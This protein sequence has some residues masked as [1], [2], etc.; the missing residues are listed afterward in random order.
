MEVNVTRG[1]Q[2]DLPVGHLQL[3]TEAITKYNTTIS[4]HAK[5]AMV[6]I[7]LHITIAMIYVHRNGRWCL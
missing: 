1:S 4:Q 6:R 7:I 5:V 2:P 3:G